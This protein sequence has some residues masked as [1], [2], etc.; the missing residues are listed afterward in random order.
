[1]TTL[2]I[3]H[4]G[5]GPFTVAPLVR[6][7]AAPEAAAPETTVLA[8]THPGWNGAPL[9][10]SIRSV[11]DLARWHLDALAD[12]GHEN[13]VVIGSSIGGWV[14]AE[15]TLQDQDAAGS[16]V[17]A[18]VIINSVG[19]DV[20]GHPMAD[21][22]ALDPRGV[23]EHSFHAPD[24]FFVDPSTLPPQEQAVRRENANSLRILA[25]DPY[26]H[27]PTLRARLADLHRPTL[28]VWG[29]SDRIATLGY[30]RALAAAIPGAAFASVPEA[31]H[32]PHIE[33][34][35]ATFAAIDGFL[36]KLGD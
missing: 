15:M 2:L 9:P 23:A 16:R 5:G 31:G 20:P 32:L 25:G 3:L 18:T 8:P 6:H 34:P 24:R 10:A 26:M 14:A 28:V 29:E 1:M 21:F 7:Y 4:G 11:P 19:I 12:A 27:D 36:D 33:Q 17:A 13:V 22:F 35:E 30:G